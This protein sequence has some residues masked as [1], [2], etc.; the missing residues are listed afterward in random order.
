MQQSL[1]AKKI[2]KDSGIG[3][4]THSHVAWLTQFTKSF[5]GTPFS[6][7]IVYFTNKKKYIYLQPSL[8]SPTSASEAEPL[9]ED[10]FS[11]MRTTNMTITRAEQKLT[12]L[13]SLEEY[14]IKIVR[15]L[16]QSVRKSSHVKQLAT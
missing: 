15:D 13:L 6:V 16:P 3:S 14:K 8:S 10:L 12:T 5:F 9:S 1:V 2:M 4:L 7:A 11:T